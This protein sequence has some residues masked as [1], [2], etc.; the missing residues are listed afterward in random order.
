VPVRDTVWVVPALPPEL[1]VITR[2]AVSVPASRGLKVIWK[3]QLEFGAIE[4][5]A[6][7]VV[8]DAIA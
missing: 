3:T 8:P 2:F 4:R 1:S 7:H 6:V 5:F